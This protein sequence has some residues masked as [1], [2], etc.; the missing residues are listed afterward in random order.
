MSQAP[1]SIRFIPRAELDAHKWDGC[2]NNASNG[3][4]Y[5]YS[6]Y[7]D[8]MSRNWDALVYGDYE[9]VMPLAWNKKWNIHYLYQPFL[10]AQLGLFGNNIDPGI[11]ES[12]LDSIPPR[13]RYWDFYLNHQNVLSLKKYTLYERRNFVLELN[14]PYDE[15]YKDYRENIQRNIRR[16][17][18]MGCERI[19]N[20]EAE[21]V[22][23][24]ATDQMR[25]YTKESAE[26]V[27][28]FRKLYDY[29]KE[30]GKAAT[31]GILSSSGQ[32]IASSIF[33]YSH[34]RAYYILVGNHPD[35]RTVGAS[36]LLID[37]FIRDNAGK[38]M[39][40]DF[41]GSDIRNLAFFYS[42]FGAREEKFAGLR[43]NNLPFYLRWMKK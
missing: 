37:S 23:N 30:Q 6:Y 13:F 36:H 24:L 8:R 35:G 3:L 32:L 12:F 18:Q 7:L 17:E 33:L 21:K 16:A 1:S 10:T 29:L 20:F 27:E 42:S 14:R 26:N 43:L 5:A 41:E 19:K 40:L 9:A 4:I 25:T 31:Y 15:L 28:R 38:P 34:A 2:I 39:L 22:I 11:L